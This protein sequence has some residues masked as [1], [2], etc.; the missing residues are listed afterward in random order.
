M[1]VGG[2]L[3]TRYPLSAVAQ[4][5]YHV[6]RSSTGYRQIN[7]ETLSAMPRLMPRPRCTGRTIPFLP[8]KS[9]LDRDGSS[10]STPDLDRGRLSESFC[11]YQ[12]DR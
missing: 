10:N 1:L 5:L 7:W 8:F 11:A 2:V 9:L 4:E 3:S 6:Q 12:D